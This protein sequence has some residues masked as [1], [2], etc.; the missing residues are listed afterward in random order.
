MARLL[1][2]CCDQPMW[3]RYPAVHEALTVVR[4]YTKGVPTGKVADILGITVHAANWRLKLLLEAG[5][6][7]RTYETMEGG[8][9]TGVW[10]AGEAPHDRP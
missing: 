8:G 9:R 10:H 5:F 1:C 2:E 6:V 7:Y 4:F 3:K